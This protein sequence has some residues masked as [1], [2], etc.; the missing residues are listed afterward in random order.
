LQEHL[1]ELITG[2][3]I[4]T[5]AVKEVEKLSKLAKHVSLLQ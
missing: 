3:G 1:G 4:I 5:L 2:A